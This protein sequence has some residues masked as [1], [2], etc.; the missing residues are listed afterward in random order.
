[1][2]LCKGELIPGEG[3]GCLVQEELKGIQK[4][5]IV[6]LFHVCPNIPIPYL[7]VCYFPPSI[8]T[9][10]GYTVSAANLPLLLSDLNFVFGHI[11]SS[12]TGDEMFLQR[13]HAGS[14]FL[15]IGSYFNIV[16]FSYLFPYV[17]SLEP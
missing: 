3:K 1:M 17:K 15:Q 13:F 9:W 6:R 7:K 8:S 5:K 12:I 4:F 10:H 16:D 2:V 14:L 11:C